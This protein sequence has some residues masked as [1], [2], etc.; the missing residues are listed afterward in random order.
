M[1]NK[2]LLL[3]ILGITF[4]T[5]TSAQNEFDSRGEIGIKLYNGGE[6]YKAGI[7]FQ[8]L[9]ADYPDEPF[10]WSGYDYYIYVEA[11]AWANA[12]ETDKAFDIL[13]ELSEKYNKYSYAMVYE[14]LIEDEN[15]ETLHKYK[16]WEELTEKVKPIHLKMIPFWLKLHDFYNERNSLLIV[17]YS[18]IEEN[19]Q[20]SNEAITLINEYNELYASIYKETTDCIDANGIP[21][22]DPVSWESQTTFFLLFNNVDLEDLS[23]Y[24]PI[25]R[26]AYVNDDIYK[27]ELAFLEDQLVMLQGNKQ[28]YGTH[29]YQDETGEK[30]VYPIEDPEKVDERRKEYGLSRI[31]DFLYNEGVYWDIE[32]HKKLVEKFDLENKN[33]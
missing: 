19:G 32:K 9:Y 13:F 33:K 8:K 14:E 11:C 22:L 10:G 6:Y 17:L 27:N 7:F 3:L 25:I 16:Q 23:K 12:N 15:F 21:G 24:L 1:I 30:F 2:Y 5:I 29:I 31:Q 4:S 26:E 28:I 20:E 18:S